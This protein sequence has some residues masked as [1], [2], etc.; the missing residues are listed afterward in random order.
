MSCVLRV[1]VPLCVVLHENQEDLRA[2]RLSRHTTKTL[3]GT[4]HNDEKRGD[5]VCVQWLQEYRSESKI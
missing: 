3:Y 4:N 1:Y 5:G 2:P